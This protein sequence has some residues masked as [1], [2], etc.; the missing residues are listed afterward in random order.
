MSIAQIIVT[1]TGVSLAAFVIWFFLFSKKKTKS[2][3]KNK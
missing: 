2:V 1:I 3:E